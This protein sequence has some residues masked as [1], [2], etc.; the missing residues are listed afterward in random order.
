MHPAYRT[1]LKS[2]NQT[3]LRWLSVLIIW[4]LSLGCRADNNTYEFKLENGLRLIVRE[5]H[6]APLVSTQVWYKVGSSYEVN[7]ITGISHALEHMMFRGTKRYPNDQFSRL[8]AVSGGDQNAFTYYDFTA[9]HQELD[10]NRLSL[11]FELEADRMANLLLTEQAFSKELN[12]VME[13][14]RLRIDDN[15]EAIAHERFLAAAHL[16]NPYH[17]PIIGWVNDIQNLKIEDLRQWYKTWYGPNNAIVVVVGD[18]NAQSIYEL[19]KTH[20]GPVKAIS[21]PTLKPR[22][23]QSPLGER[24]LQ[25]KQRTQVSRLLMGY[26][27]PSILTANDPTDAYALLVLLMAVD[28]GNSGRF[29]QHLI[30]GDCVACAIDSSY[31][32]FQ[33]H[34]TLLTFSAMPSEGQ[35]LEALEQSITKQLVRLQT[36][37]LTEQELKRVKVNVIAQYTFSRDSMSNQ[38]LEIGMLESIGLSWQESERYPENIQKVTAEQVLQ[39]AKKYLTP[40]RL[41]VTHLIPL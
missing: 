9:Y 40:D 25:V 5:D 31:N 13:E 19:A 35:S 38:A 33:L 30:R 10:V 8:I 26:N 41:T 27:V 28:G 34:E 2:A 29:S 21:L 7:G 11:C 20:F 36:E 12:I 1:K 37:P 15:P 22:L 4:G 14:R 23:E 3:T 32:P 18:V 39:V 6:R 17:H 24:R 16:S